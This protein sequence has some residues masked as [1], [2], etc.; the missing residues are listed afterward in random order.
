M[1]A[2]FCLSLMAL[3][4]LGGVSQAQGV[5]IPVSV[6]EALFPGTGSVVLDPVDLNGD[7]VDEVLVRRPSDCEGSACAWALMQNTPEGWS[8][9]TAGRAA[10]VDFAQAGS[11]SALVADG[12]LWSWNGEELYPAADL[13]E[14]TFV[15]AS[16]EDL[17]LAYDLLGFSTG[18]PSG[19]APTGY[20]TSADVDGD[21]AP[22][23]IIV[24][25]DAAWMIEGAYSPFAIVDHE[26]GLILS[27]YSMDVPRLYGA[28]GS[29][30]STVVSVTPAGLQVQP[31]AVGEF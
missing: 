22:D 29:L 9:I 28:S 2:R 10:R 15:E 8:P 19:G 5:D 25:A 26:G 7:G 13:L 14:G 4:L 18:I 20:S 6:A 31:I 3:G 16:L 30:A 11:S 17:R 1:I 21:G 24:I 23:R 12:V 27:G